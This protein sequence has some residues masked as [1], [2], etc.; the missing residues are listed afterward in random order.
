MQTSE[1][2]FESRLIHEQTNSYMAHLVCELYFA[3]LF[4]TLSQKTQ[5]CLISQK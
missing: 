4:D 5:M 3:T 2:E 1:T